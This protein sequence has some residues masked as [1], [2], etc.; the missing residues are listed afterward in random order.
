MADRVPRVKLVHAPEN[1]LDPGQIAAV[2]AGRRD[3]LRGAFATAAALASTRALAQA[4]AGDPAILDLPEH[5]RSLGQPV[6]ARGYGTPS[7]FERNVQ[8]R[9]IPGRTPARAS[10][11]SFT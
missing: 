7:Q 5:S 6:A 1:F 3:F 10:S 4:P 8:Q 2:Q 11:E 9:E